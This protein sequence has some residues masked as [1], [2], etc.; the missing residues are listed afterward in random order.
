MAQTLSTLHRGIITAFVRANE[1][2]DGSLTVTMRR[3]DG[4]R[5]G[6][7]TFVGR[8]ETR[9]AADA[10]QRAAVAASDMPLTESQREALRLLA[11]RDLSP[12][13]LGSTT[14]NRL[15]NAGYAERVRFTNANLATTKLRI[16]AAG[17][18]RL[19]Q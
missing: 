3:H 1:P 15:C 18:A 12:W 2:A 14:V 16:T 4:R 19:A 5:W 8:Y 13:D 9:Q 6:P 10:A 7:E 17:R 11:L